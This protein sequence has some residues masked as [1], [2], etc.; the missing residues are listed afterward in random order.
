M[1]VNGIGAGHQIAGYD[2]RK[3]ER[4]V[5]S[6]TVGFMEIVE[7]KAAQDNAIDYDEKA[8]EMVAPRAPQKVKDA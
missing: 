6:G 7:E 3:A 4:N 8:F 1:S 2:A 5:D